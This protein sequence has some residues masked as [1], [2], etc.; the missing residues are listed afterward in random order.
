MTLQIKL[1]DVILDCEVPDEQVIAA[2]SAAL[3]PQVKIEPVE[4]LE[5]FHI[6]LAKNYIKDLIASTEVCLGR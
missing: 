3:Y 5:D 2:L 4:D 6:L 1:Y